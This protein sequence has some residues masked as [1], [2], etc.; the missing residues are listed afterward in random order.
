MEYKPKVVIIGAGLAG[1]EAARVLQN[2][3]VNI[4]IIEKHNQ[5][6]GHLREWFKLFPYFRDASDLLQLY[7]QFHQNVSFYTDMSIL[8]V[9]KEKGKFKIYTT[10]NKVFEADCVLITTGFSLFDAQ[11]KEEYGYGIFSNVLTN[12]DLERLFR[13]QWK[14]TNSSLSHKFAFIHCVGSRDRK[15]GHLYCSKVC[16]ATAIKQA[17]EIKGLFPASSVYCFY[18]DLRLHD[19]YFEH[20]FIAAQEKYGVQFIRGRVSE[21]NE[22]P[23]NKLQLKF[24][25]TLTSQPMKMTFDYVVLMAGMVPASDTV[26]LAQSF[27]LTLDEDGFFAV[28]DKQILENITSV[29]GVFL[30]G[31]VTGPKTI[32]ETIQDARTAA[33][34][35]MEYLHKTSQE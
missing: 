27:G 34:F 3:P 25:D 15:V 13:T 20:L 26:S 12:L 8:N 14:H 28:K 4:S 19:K 23:D 24:E 6:G 1:L 2:F 17:I 16:C 7:D 9:K 32:T 31:T 21:I 10:K 30:A 18:M 29:D 35:I 11:K 5:K 33:M 22:L